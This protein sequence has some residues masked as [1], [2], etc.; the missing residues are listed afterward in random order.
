MGEKQRH[1][2]R[3][4]DAFRKRQRF[5]RPKNLGGEYR[6][7]S[8]LPK[9]LGS[10]VNITFNLLVDH[11]VPPQIIEGLKQQFDI[12]CKTPKECGINGRDDRKIA[13]V[14]KNKQLIVLTRNHTDFFNGNMIQ[15]HK[16]FGIFALDYRES[17]QAM[18]AMIAGMGAIINEIGP[19]VA[20]DWWKSTKVKFGAESCNLTRHEGLVVRRSIVVDPSTGKA[21]FK[22]I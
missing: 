6:H 15:L 17:E 13:E 16:C 9:Y 5:S 3:Y 22:S 18:Y 12:K 20:W 4:E 8:E 11:D 21:W 7:V 19:Y 14:A 1:K 10:R 2:N